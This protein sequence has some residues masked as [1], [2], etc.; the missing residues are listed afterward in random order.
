MGARGAGLFAAMAMECAEALLNSLFRDVAEGHLLRVDIEVLELRLEHVLAR[1]T[2]VNAASLPL[3]LA[4]AHFTATRPAGPG[5]GLGQRRL[6]GGAP[7]LA[8]VTLGFGAA[9]FFAAGFFLAAGMAVEGVQ[10]VARLALWLLLR[11]GPQVAAS[12]RGLAG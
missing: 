9:F 2:F 7:A 3:T 4:G 6:R 11:S 8:F 10:V 12:R 5:A 1:H